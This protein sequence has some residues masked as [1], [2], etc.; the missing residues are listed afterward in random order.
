VDLAPRVMRAALL[1]LRE[2]AVTLAELV[3]ATLA[4]LVSSC[5]NRKKVRM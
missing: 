2:A 5:A 3:L 4:S 1:P